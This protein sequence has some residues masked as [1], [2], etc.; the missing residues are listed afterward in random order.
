M[1]HTSV[2]GEQRGNLV[3]LTEK[4]DVV[5]VGSVETV[6]Y[7]VTKGVDEEG[8]I[9]YTVVTYKLEEAI[10][11][12]KKVGDKLVLKFVGGADGKGGFM[13]VSGVPQFQPGEKDL[14]FVKGNGEDE[15]CPLVNCEYGRYRI[16]NGQM[17][18]THGQPVRG[19]VKNSAVARGER[20][21]VFE[22][23]SYPTPSFDE[24]MK[25]P[26][27]QAM[28]TKMGKDVNTARAEY[29][30]GKP[31]NLVVVR[32]PV[33]GRKISDNAG[34]DSNAKG[35]RSGSSLKAAIGNNAIA[36]TDVLK[37]VKSLH[38][39]SRRK[40][41]AFKDANH[42]TGMALRKAVKKSPGRLVD[43]KLVLTGSKKDQDEE[44]AV[45]A[46]DGNPVMKRTR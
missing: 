3:E 42:K 21:K 6:N 7:I 26:H 37:T 40:P 14:L 15:R 11:G 9:P 17:Y 1:S 5:A 4:S 29:E 18:N 33:A 41:V 28:L 8:E 46:Q 27:A 35:R 45:R 32:T 30:K 23:F 2:T 43:K 10:R 31:K 12:N 19:M 25:N 44:K 24:L 34:A 39:K 13:T 38:S 16:H 36:H 22:T 20:A